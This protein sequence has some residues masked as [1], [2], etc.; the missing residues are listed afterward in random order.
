MRSP[1]RLSK[2]D[3]AH[4]VTHDPRILNYSI[5][6]TLKVRI[7]SFLSHGLLAA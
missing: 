5:D 3:V 7:S 4:V 2:A 6:N 1:R